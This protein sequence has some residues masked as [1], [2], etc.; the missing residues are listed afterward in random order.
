MSR[1]FPQATSQA[2]IVTLFCHPGF[3]DNWK[4]SVG[5]GMSIVAVNLL[6]HQEEMS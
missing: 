6:S 1:L 5:V 3:I 4:A 2:K